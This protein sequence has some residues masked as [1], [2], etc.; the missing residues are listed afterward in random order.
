MIER[1]EDNLEA[2]RAVCRQFGV[3]RLETYQDSSYDENDPD[4]SPVRFL[5]DLGPDGVGSAWGA[6]DLALALE[7]VVGRMVVLTERRHVQDRG[8]LAATAKQR[9]TI[10]ESRKQKAAA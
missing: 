5:V 2:I 9:V 10:H 8:Y 4:W 7:A 6:I 1:V 3:E